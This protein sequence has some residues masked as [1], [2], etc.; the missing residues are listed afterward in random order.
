MYV[1]EVPGATPFAWNM[2]KPSGNS[3]P[4]GLPAWFSRE[5]ASEIAMA[6]LMVVADED[7]TDALVLDPE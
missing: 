1:A 7:V 3:T 5:L 2:T 4:S 6:P